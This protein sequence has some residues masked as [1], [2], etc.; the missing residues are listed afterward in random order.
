MTV[1]TGT[2]A[3]INADER[4]KSAIESS[5]SDN[6]YKFDMT[7]DVAKEALINDEI[8]GY[9]VVNKVEGKYSPDFYKKPTSRDITL[10]NISSALEKL[11]MS[12]V[13]SELGLSEEQVNRL[14]SNKV[15]I[16]TIRVE[17]NKDGSNSQ[18]SESDPS[19]F[20]KKGL[21]YVVC[22]MV[23]IFIMNYVGI[24][25][26]EIAAEKGS[27]IMEI[28]LSSV[29]A[30]T[31]FFGKMIG[32][33]FVIL[34][35]VVIYIG[36]FF[37]GKGV[38]N[39]FKLLDKI[40]MP[41]INI[42]QILGSATN[43]ILIS[44]VYA[45]L[46][47]LIYTSIAGFLGSLVSRTEDVQKTVMPIT[48]IG[49]VGFYIGMYAL[50]NANNPLVQISSQIP[51]FTPFVMPFRMASGTVSSLEITLSIIISII[52]TVICLWL[53]S[54]FYKS[55]VLIYSEKGVINTFKKSVQL[56]KSERKLS[57]KN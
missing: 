43:D 10:T 46:G 1:K 21:A 30:T 49:V 18:T 12:D 14:N 40:N 24:I 16:N 39:H 54:M 47:I 51:L 29:S 7:P 37:I 8:D 44:L 33:G 36:M 9:L 17:N 6:T 56:F 23:F 20:V 48:L 52:F 45:I 28:I 4:A 57:N 42:A 50:T 32:I 19:F 35:Q 26:Q 3:V 13:R 53:S 15:E 5:A 11:Q 2:I 34:T 31:H 38:V 41:N 22:F 27:R 55:N 25:S